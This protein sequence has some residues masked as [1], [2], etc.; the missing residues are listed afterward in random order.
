MTCWS[1][2]QPPS[3]LR[4]GWKTPAAGYLRGERQ[5]PRGLLPGELLLGG[6]TVGQVEQL[7]VDEFAVGEEGFHVRAQVGVEEAGV[8][9]GWAGR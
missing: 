4:S 5:E 6:G 9:P 8:G 7:G 1:L 2:S 3:P